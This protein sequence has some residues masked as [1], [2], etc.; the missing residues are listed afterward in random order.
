MSAFGGDAIQLTFEANLTDAR[1]AYEQFIEDVSRR[2]VPIQ[3][4]AGG[5]GRC[6]RLVRL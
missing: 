1:R 6:R 5:A 2:P 4:Q 3:F